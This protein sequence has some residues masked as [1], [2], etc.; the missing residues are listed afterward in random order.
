MNYTVLIITAIA[1]AIAALI[2]KIC[3]ARARRRHP[4]DMGDEAFQLL[5]EK[6][7]GNKYF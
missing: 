1:V 6:Q 3:D 5:L 4:L 2:K 7:Y